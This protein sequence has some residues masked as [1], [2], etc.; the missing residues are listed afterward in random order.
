[1]NI[2]E[3]E[4]NILAILLTYQDKQAYIF[5]KC[6]PEFF[7]DMINRKIYTYANEIYAKGDDVDNVSIYMASDNNKAISDRMID[8]LTECQPNSISTRRYCN[9][10]A[11]EYLDRLVKEAKS[12]DDLNEIEAVQNNYVDSG[13]EKIKHISDGA[14]HF[15]EN[16]KKKQEKMI[17]TGFESVDRVIGSF[18]GGDYIALGGAT[19]MGKTSIA[20]N[21]TKMFCAMGNK[22]L[23]CSLEMPLE[24]LQNRYAS[25]TVGLNASKFRS[26]GFTKEEFEKYQEALNTLNEWSLYVLCDYNLT[27]EKLKIYAM[28]QMKHGLDVIVID[29]LGLLNGY[30]NKAL[31]E[32]STII[33]R[34]IKVLATELNI[35]ILVLVQLN[36]SLKDRADKRPILSDIRESGAIEQDADFVLFA[37]RPYVYSNDESQKNDLEIIV[38]KNRHGESNAICQLDFNL[39]TQEISNKSYYGFPKGVR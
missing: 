8:I 10:L 13:S 3:V 28:E 18:C 20:L 9:I 32:K 2:N 4:T 29:Y 25:M 12:I 33:S 17:Q 21:F 36:R 19:G 5:E 6:K 24:Q 35:P 23:Y 34:K 14:E 1:M 38:A 26:T 37:H 27:V 31:Y 11:K 39:Q 30:N 15:M 16:F 22:V 7:S